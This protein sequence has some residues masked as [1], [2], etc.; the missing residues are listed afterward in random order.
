[1]T[2]EVAQHAPRAVR[3]V[4]HR[5]VGRHFLDR[6]VEILLGHGI[7]GVHLGQEK[8][9]VEDLPHRQCLATALTPLMIR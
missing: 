8:L 2:I 4:D 5:D 1:M 3:R 6:L 9:P 7:L